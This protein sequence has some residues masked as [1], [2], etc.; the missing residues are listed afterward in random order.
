MEL[1]VAC[2]TVL[3]VTLA[4]LTKGQ[5]PSSLLGMALVTMM[6]LGGSLQTLLINWSGLETSLGAVSR[7]KDFTETTPSEASAA[8]EI[9]V[10]EDWPRLGTLEMKSVSLTY[11]LVEAR[12]KVPPD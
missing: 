8:G 2:L 1:T 11:G 4:I 12:N 7:V 10:G 6:G 9:V 3:L 5:F